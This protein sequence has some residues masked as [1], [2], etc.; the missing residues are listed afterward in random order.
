MVR[1]WIL[2]PALL[3]GRLTKKTDGPAPETVPE[4]R[5]AASY[6]KSP[7]GRIAPGYLT[8]VAPKS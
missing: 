3:G 2:G 1:G 8:I 6:R 4:F 7:L 5:W